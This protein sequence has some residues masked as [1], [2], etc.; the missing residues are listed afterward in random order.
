M[1]KILV[2]AAAA[3]AMLVAACNTI[4]GAGRDV[5]AVGH[6]VAETARDAK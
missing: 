3:A 6:A 4:E 5:S 2:L 1:R